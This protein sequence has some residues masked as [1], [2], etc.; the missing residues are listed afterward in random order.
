MPKVV[1]E[2]RQ[3]RYGMIFSPGL[4]VYL[5]FAIAKFVEIK[6]GDNPKTTQAVQRLR[7]FFKEYE[8]YNAK[9]KQEDEQRKQNKKRLTNE[10]PK[11]K[12][13]VPVQTAVEK[14]KSTETP[15]ESTGLTVPAKH[16]ATSKTTQMS[17]LPSTNRKEVKVK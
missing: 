2:I 11:H 16:P 15:M 1:E 12:K 14:T 13:L 8:D 17:A 10:T 7:N 4:Y 6:L 5:H 3:Q 9:L